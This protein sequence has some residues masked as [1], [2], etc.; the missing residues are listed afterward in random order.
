MLEQYCLGCMSHA[1]V[2]LPALQVV[3]QA[4][5][6]LPALQVALRSQV[7]GDGNG[8][9]GSTPGTTRQQQ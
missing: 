4:G 3:S 1:G 2:H 8:S 7:G 5:V 6:H 9:S